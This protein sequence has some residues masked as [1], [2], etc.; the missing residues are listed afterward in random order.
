MHGFKE[1]AGENAPVDRH[2]L[3]WRKDGTETREFFHDAHDLA[4]R[5]A[6]LHRKG[7]SA[8]SVRGPGGAAI[9]REALLDQGKKHLAWMSDPWA[10]ADAAGMVPMPATR[11][12]RDQWWERRAAAGAAATFAT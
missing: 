10:L 9:S 3:A 8:W 7:V 12:A 5:V 2:V 4:I 6:R 1:R 11:D